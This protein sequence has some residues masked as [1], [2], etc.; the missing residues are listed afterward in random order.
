[1]AWSSG[2]L[3]LPSSWSFGRSKVSSRIDSGLLRQNINFDL[4]C[5]MWATFAGQHDRTACFRFAATNVV[6]TYS[7][8]LLQIVSSIFPD[9]DGRLAGCFCRTSV[10]TSSDLLGHGKALPLS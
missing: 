6:E 3:C 7:A 8:T 4:E 2:G 9:L 5:Y 10:T 1:M